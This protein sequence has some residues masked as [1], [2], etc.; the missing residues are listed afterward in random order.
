MASLAGMEEACAPRSEASQWVV[1][2]LGLWPPKS[3]QSTLSWLPKEHRRPMRLSGKVAM[4]TGAA[5]RPPARTALILRILTCMINCLV[6]VAIVKG[7]PFELL[8]HLPDSL[9]QTFKPHPVSVSV[10]QSVDYRC[11]G[12]ALTSSFLYG[13]SR[14]SNQVMYEVTRFHDP[15]MVPDGAVPGYKAF[16]R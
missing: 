10:A 5:T 15:V 3:G 6:M 4:I 12:V 2:S 14:V 11:R 16:H 9:I 8:V 1:T 13:G 7:S